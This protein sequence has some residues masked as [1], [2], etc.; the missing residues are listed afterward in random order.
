MGPRGW[1]SM[2]VVCRLSWRREG[3]ALCG[4]R[5]MAGR[6]PPP[7]LRPGRGVL[8][9]VLPSVLP[10]WARSG[11]LPGARHF[12]GR[13]FVCAD[14][15]GVADLH[16]SQGCGDHNPASPRR[17]SCSDPHQCAGC[18]FCAY[19]VVGAA[20][21]TCAWKHLVFGIPEEHI[22]AVARGRGMCT[23]VSCFC[24]G[25]CG[26]VRC[27]LPL[28]CHPGNMRRSLYV[29]LGSKVCRCSTRRRSA[30]GQ[31]RR[32]RIQATGHS[33]HDGPPAPRS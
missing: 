18:G 29:V 14:R 8:A 11:W 26:R 28:H 5:R 33:D 24:C 25:L 19:W 31:T 12:Q 10:A 1:L 3:P 7:P 13:A 27:Y 22:R 32:L 6:A 21:W 2:A 4:Q 20:V 16:G 15:G 17:L 30:P 23:W 9:R